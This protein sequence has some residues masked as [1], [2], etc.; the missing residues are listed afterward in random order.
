VLKFAL[1]NLWAYKRRLLTSAFSVVLGVSF[2]AG[3]FVF[4]D[5]LKGLFED[6]F[7]SALKGVDVV[8]RGPKEF[9]LG[10]AG[11]PYDE[12]RPSV[13][14]SLV[15]KVRAVEGVAAAENSIQGYAQL[16]DKKGK[17]VK[18]GGAPTFGR[19]WNTDREI[20][21]F[22]ILN[23]RPPRSDDEIVIDRSLAEKTGYRV[24]DRVKVSTAG[25]LRTFRVSGDATFGSSNGQLGA[26][27]IFF[28]QDTAQQVMLRSG[29]TQSVIVRGDGSVSEETLRRRVGAALEGDTTV[30]GKPLEVITGAA[31]DKEI[32]SILD[33][34]FGFIN[35]FFTAFAVVALFVSI[36]VISN[37]FSIVVAQRTKEM[38][39]LRAVGATRR[40]VLG[41]TFL[42]ALAVGLLASAVGVAGGLLVA[43]GIRTL[44]DKVGGAGLPSSGLVLAP[45]TIVV[46]MLVGTV[47]TV[48]S[49]VGP[50]V[51][52]SR[53]KPL[54]ALR[55]VAID[56][57]GR[58]RVRL[59]IGTVLAVLSVVA[60][61]WG[62]TGRGS[63]G[64]QRVGAG[65][66][67]VDVGRR[68]RRVGD[69]YVVVQRWR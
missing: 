43:L 44:L 18:T 28:T 20:N 10:R 26:T 52:A 48:L 51:R 4:T 34:V 57:S 2:L 55:D 12:G 25:P 15:A 50:A 47:V 56:R 36:F 60:T 58:S 33:T 31:F 30:N 17:L 39:M 23:G 42:E 24:G 66:A 16:I 40:Q 49:S 64:A 7:S 67:V 63:T 61:A 41:S 45:R 29:E 38:A 22:R 3:S 5:T 53:V 32:Q 54:A 19:V 6:L 1:R 65:A 46:G 68:W 37:S 59:V 14:D 35:L 9:D 21:P 62:M 8:V 13:S 27:T 11:N 69:V